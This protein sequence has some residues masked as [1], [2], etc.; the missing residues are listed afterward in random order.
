[1]KIERYSPGE[2]NQDKEKYSLSVEGKTLNFKSEKKAANF[3]AKSTKL[4]NRRRSVY[5][6]KY[7]F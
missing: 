7:K 6:K 2:E 4:I 5:F 3:L 1:M